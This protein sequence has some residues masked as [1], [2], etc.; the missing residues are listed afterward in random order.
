MK[1]TNKV[2]L[3]SPDVC[4]EKFCQSCGIP[5]KK[6]CRPSQ[7]KLWHRKRRIKIG[8]RGKRDNT[9]KQ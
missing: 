1:E 6:K 9:Y 8:R 4:R 2:T 5:I 3:G 7:F